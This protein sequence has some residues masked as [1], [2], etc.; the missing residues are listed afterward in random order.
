MPR[1]SP[2]GLY[3]RVV[4]PDQEWLAEIHKELHRLVLA[5]ERI[6]RRLK[7]ETTDRDDD[8]EATESKE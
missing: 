1:V 6:E 8:Q 5:V 2:F 7:E 4:T 3:P